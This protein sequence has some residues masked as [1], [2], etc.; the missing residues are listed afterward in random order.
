MFVYRGDVIPAQEWER[1]KAEAYDRCMTE[2]SDAGME[3]MKEMTGIDWFEPGIP[4]KLPPTPAARTGDYMLA[5]NQLP[6]RLRRQA[7]RLLTRNHKDPCGAMEVF[8]TLYDAAL[9]AE[10]TGVDRTV[11][12]LEYLWEVGY[13]T[14]VMR[15]I[16]LLH[17]WLTGRD[18]FDW[19]RMQVVRL[20]A[21]GLVDRSPMR[22]SAQIP[23]DIHQRPTPLVMRPCITAD[24]PPTP[25]GRRSGCALLAA[26]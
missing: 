8:S 14:S 16:L 10:I 11:I 4:D 5:V 6:R 17:N 2:H 15:F 18:D 3:R 22:F 9:E 24:G 21:R 1:I 12:Y 26:A 7:R 25:F 19:I 13:G 23:P 20:Y